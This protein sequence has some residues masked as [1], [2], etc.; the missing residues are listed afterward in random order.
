MSSVGTFRACIAGASLLLAFGCQSLQRFD[1]DGKAAYCGQIV[2]SQFV[3]TPDTRGGFDRQM[4]LSLKLDTG[5]LTTTPGRITSSDA[6]HGPCAPSAT[7]DDAKLVV[8][9]EIVNDPLSTLT[10]EEGQVHNIVAWVDS[11]CRGKM[12]A[13]V[14]LY[15]TNHVELRLMKPG[16]EPADSSNRDAFALFMLDRNESGCG[17]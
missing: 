17:N 14:S 8:T 4:S 2:A 10:F 7:F 15:K 3:W 9:P 6:E 13:I 12:L 1:T 16:A 11:T 5:A